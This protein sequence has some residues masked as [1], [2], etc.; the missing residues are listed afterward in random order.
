M[1]HTKA[2][3]LTLWNH[4]V[5]VSQSGFCLER[6]HHVPF[7]RGIW[8]KQDQRRGYQRWA[9]SLQSFGTE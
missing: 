3:L 2:Q 7:Y 4:R 8:S 9:T 6:V 1:A 5:T